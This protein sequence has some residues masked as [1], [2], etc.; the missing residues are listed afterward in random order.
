VR[1]WFS[2]RKRPDGATRH[3]G[4]RANVSE[5][6]GDTRRRLL[7]DIPGS[8]WANGWTGLGCCPLFIQV[9]YL[10]PRSLP[11]QQSCEGSNCIWRW[12]LFARRFMNDFWVSLSTVMWF[13]DRWHCFFCFPLPTHI[14]CCGLLAEFI[15]ILPV[16]QEPGCTLTIR[17]CSS[18]LWYFTENL[19]G[20]LASRSQWTHRIYMTS[21]YLDDCYIGIT[22]VRRI[23]LGLNWL[24][25]W[26]TLFPWLWCRRSWFVNDE[27][28]CA[29]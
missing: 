11:A 5:A 20:A 8:G 3:E 19:V 7:T 23:G 22:A 9:R 6:F 16:I 10:S 26:Q 27:R 28:D 12:F 21:M 29:T 18:W 4:F 1:V 17:V 14:S 15:P 13:S 24:C 2:Q 25:L